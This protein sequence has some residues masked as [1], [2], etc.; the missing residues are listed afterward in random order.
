M[1]F[2]PAATSNK[3]IVGYYRYPAYVAPEPFYGLEFPVH[4]PIMER[5]DFITFDFYIY[6]V[7]L[8]L[9]TKSKK[10]QKIDRRILIIAAIVLL[11]LIVI[12]LSGLDLSKAWCG[13]DCFHFV[14]IASQ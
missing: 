14:G 5:K 10:H 6:T 9:Q 2:I 3:L 4:K 1:V 13:G 8:M 7:I 11:L 12:A